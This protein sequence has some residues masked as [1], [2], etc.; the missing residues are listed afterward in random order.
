LSSQ[1]G[2]EDDPEDPVLQEIGERRMVSVDELYPCEL[3]AGLN[4]KEMEQIAAIASQETYEVGELI[5]EEQEQ[6]DR[7]FILCEGRVQLHIRLRSP[8]EPDGEM[9]IAEVEPGRVFGWSSLV[10]QRRFTASARA[11]EPVTVMVL[12]AQD[13]NALF[14]RNV[15]IGFVVM[16]QLAEVIASRLR[17]T[18]EI[19]EATGVGER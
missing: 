7:L 5:I 8:L 3:F 16:K 4:D 13:L 11:L 17:H 18:R 15:H 14:D 9:T 10:K 12:E 6:A 19:C 1:K 2:L